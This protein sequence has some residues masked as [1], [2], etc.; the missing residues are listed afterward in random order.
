MIALHKISKK[1]DEFYAIKNIS[2]EFKEREIIA[3]IGPSGSGKTTLLKCINHI[4]TPTGGYISINDQKITSRNRAKLCSKIGMVF[5]NFNLFPHMD[6]L[7]NLTYSP[8]K[9][10][11][12]GATEA[13]KKASDLLVKFGLSDKLNYKPAALSGGQK[14]RVAIA[15]ALMLDPE[16]MLFDEPTSA[17]DPEV[18]K[19]VIEIIKSL[20]DQMSTI[21]VTHHVKFAKAVATRV[22]FMDRGQIL[23]DQ[24]KEAFFNKPTSHRARL[25][26]ENIGD[27]I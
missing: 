25:F 13:N 27:L 18:I 17:L 22:I 4:E 14:Q 8:I 11:K 5:Q 3:I 21:I 10:Y 1:Y 15:R 23:A 20:K 7:A 6:I 19:D 9:I 26:L 12:M 24:P 2:L 16:V